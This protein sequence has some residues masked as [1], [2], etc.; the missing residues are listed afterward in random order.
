MSDAASRRQKVELLVRLSAARLKAWA[1]LGVALVGRWEQ[2]WV[3]EQTGEYSVA[4]ALRPGLELTCEP[5]DRRAFAAYTEAMERGATA[6][7]AARLVERAAAEEL[8]SRDCP[9]C[10]RLR[11][12]EPPELE[13]LAALSALADPSVGEPER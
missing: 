9:H 11:A 7:E 8:A 1:E 2:R 13:T 6:A 5:C 4:A 12:P 3:A 10:E